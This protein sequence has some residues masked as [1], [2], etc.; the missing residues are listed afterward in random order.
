MVTRSDGTAGM[1][2]R[3]TSARQRFAVASSSSPS[4]FAMTARYSS[5]PQRLTTSKERTLFCSVLATIFSTSSP[6]LVAVPVIDDL[7]I[8]DIDENDAE[9]PAVP[10]QFVD[11]GMQRDLGV[12]PVGK[13]G[14]RIEVGQ[15]F[16]FGKPLQGDRCRRL[17]REDLDAA[18][19][20]ALRRS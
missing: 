4:T 1:N 20:L 19:D 15:P 3:S 2:D 12:P 18:D 8:V 17:S 10:L 6:Q 16:Q 11:A 7:E 13:P 5:P 14:E 9:Q